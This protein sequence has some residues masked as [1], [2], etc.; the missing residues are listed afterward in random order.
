[1]RIVRHL[2]AFPAEFRGGAAVIGNFDGVHRGHRALIDRAIDCAQP[3]SAPV[4]AL[5][6]EPHPRRVFAPDSPP[7]RLTPFRT[8]ARLLKR[9][10]VDVLVALRFAAPLHQKPAETFV[11]DILVDGIG[12][13][14]VV[15][16]YDFVFGH[17]RGGNTDLLRSLGQEHGYEVAI[18]DP[19]VHGDDVCSSTMIRV[20]LE[21]G[22]A[23]RAAD[24]LGHWWEVQG[25]VRGGDRRG[26]QI[27]FPTANLHLGPSSLRP[28][29][30]VY[31][32]HMGLEN[33]GTTQWIPAV[34]NLGTRPTFDGQGVVLEVHAFAEV[35]DIYGRHV[36]V[37]FVDHLRPERKFNGIDEI[38][39]QIAA[40][41]EE[42]R[43]RLADPNNAVD[44]FT[45]G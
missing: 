44:L 33:G 35:G 45:R 25:R 30:G 4:V 41:C 1:M 24:L 15:V 22:R 29:L 19:V 13:R 40:D 37:A 3:A 10:G 6:F 23:R 31:A 7:F 11:A 26:R 21:T 5:T 38:R 36:R 18:V 20:N 2:S 8:K 14:H 27:G 28:A 39:T 34:A 16:G 32:V 9:F 17:R 12:A 43:R 42:A